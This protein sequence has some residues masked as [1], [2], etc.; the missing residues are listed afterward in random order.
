MIFESRGGTPTHRRPKTRA[1]ERRLPKHQMIH[2]PE[3]ALKS[4]SPQKADVDVSSR[5]SKCSAWGEFSPDIWGCLKR[6]LQKEGPVGQKTVRRM[7]LV[8][9]HWCKGISDSV[10]VL[11]PNLNVMTLWDLEFLERRFTKLKQLILCEA[12][13]VSDSWLTFIAKATPKLCRLSIRSWDLSGGGLITDKGLMSLLGLQHLSHLELGGCKNLTNFGLEVLSGIPT[14]RHIDIEDCKRISDGGLVVISHLPEI[15]SLV[16]AG[17][18]R[19]TDF[20]LIALTPLTTLESINL[21]GCSNIT[22]VGVRSLSTLVS[23]KRLDIRVCP[24]V[25]GEGFH[26]LTDLPLNYLDF[27][28]CSGITNDGAWGVA[29]LTRL[30]HLDI[31]RCENLNDIGFGAL[32]NLRGLKELHLGGNSITDRGFIRISN[33]TSLTTLVLCDLTK[34]SEKGMDAIC[35]LKCLRKLTVY[36]CEKVPENGLDPVRKS[37]GAS[38]C[39]DRWGFGRKE[40]SSVPQEADWIV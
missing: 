6:L 27:M 3:R 8:N 14:L 17:C 12:S 34:I 25:A 38:L 21:K 37:I 7:R 31:K 19:I 2:P 1:I 9:K 39:I 11:T 10:S 36:G 16:V 33:L 32:Q 26:A 20:G 13:T 22:D 23:L 29:G 40:N 5:D 28:G 30:T 24:N 15:R 4:D 18:T 35:A